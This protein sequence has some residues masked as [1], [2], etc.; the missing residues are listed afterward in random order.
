MV[1]KLIQR[2]KNRKLLKSQEEY[3]YPDIRRSNIISQILINQVYPRHIIIKLSE[4]N[5]NKKI[6]KAAR[7]E[8]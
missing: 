2:N 6:L 1:V 8:K 3:R 7:Q 4:M 5:D